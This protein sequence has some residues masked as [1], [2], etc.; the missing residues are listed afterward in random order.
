MRR[1]RPAGLGRWA[2]ALVAGALLLSACT[3]GG[4]STPGPS[5]HTRGPSPNGSLLIALGEEF[6]GLALL[7]LGTPGGPEPVELTGTVLGR[8]DVIAGATLQDDGTAYAL[9][10]KVEG[11]QGFRLHE[12]G[13]QLFELRQ[14]QQPRKLGP[15]L[16]PGLATLVGVAGGRAVVSSCGDR[17]QP[18]SVLALDL[19]TGDAAG[20][21]R[22]VVRA[23]QAT[24]S[25]DATDVA[26]V[27]DTPQGPSI[28]R[29]S[30]DRPSP[31]VRLAGPDVIQPLERS[32]IG[33]PD[34]FDL[35]WGEGGVAAAVADRRED[36]SRS[37]LVVLP[38]GGPP[39]VIP[40]GSGSPQD[41]AWQP[42]GTLLAVTECSRCAQFFRG[43]PQ[44]ELFVFDAAGGRLG[45]IAA[46]REFFQG[47]AWS[48]DGSLL[49][50]EPSRGDLALLDTS[51][52]EVLRL[53]TDGAP[54]D[55]GTG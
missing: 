21:W 37:G 36:V 15:P 42:G 44:G 7:P 22:P 11:N 50:T 5:R 6:S 4:Q 29:V 47:L 46:S 34:V 49:A 20:T 55:W 33:R 18:S 54:L 17:D 12:V 39:R 32:G 16:G 2:V 27:R 23:C 28:W 13:S 3:G 1:D 31:P 24:L 8:F 14:G 10:T 35:A 45:E 43:V 26:F 25:P 9:V 30:L 40:L 48:P 51:G 52:R 41:L 38:D 53:A 19:A